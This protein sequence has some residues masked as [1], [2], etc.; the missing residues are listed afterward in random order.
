LSVSKKSTRQFLCPDDLWKQLEEAASELEAPIDSLIV[1]AVRK[2]LRPGRP[3]P[4]AIPGACLS[5]APVPD[6][7]I[8]PPKTLVISHAGIDYVVRAPIFVIG[9]DPSCDLVISGPDVGARHAV[10]ELLNGA[11]YVVDLGAAA[12]THC[13]GH[14]FVRKRID[15]GD[16][17]LLVGHRLV[18]RLR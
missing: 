8:G 16:E 2:F 9:S 3:Q 14:R 18:C 4:V 13:N 7:P 15:D 17:I 10:F 5:L 1:S 12:G 6:E 11:H